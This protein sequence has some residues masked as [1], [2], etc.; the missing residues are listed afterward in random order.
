MRGREEEAL[1]EELIEQAQQGYVDAYEELVRIHQGA[2]TQ[3]AYLVSGS[4]ADADDIAQEAFV[5]A[6]LALPRFRAG[7]RFRPWLLAIVGNVARNHRRA[8]GRRDRLVL[9]I[10]STLG[11]S[12]LPGAEDDVCSAE[13]RR[14][15]LAAVNG[16]PDA[17]RLVIACRYFAGLSEA[18]TA[19]ALGCRPGTVKSRL[20]RA[21]DRLRSALVVPPEVPAL[22]QESHG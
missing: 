12:T 16:L 20:S 2:A 6:Y 8:H 22:E 18:E 15:L 14:H 7:S 4:R 21:H 9:R 5:R 3:V 10:Q 11:P 1:D 19:A 17:H 13:G